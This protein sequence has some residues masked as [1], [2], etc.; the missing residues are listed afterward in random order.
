[1]KKSKKIKRWISKNLLGVK[2]NSGRPKKQPIVKKPPVLPVVKYQQQFEQPQAQIKGNG[3]NMRTLGWIVTVSVVAVGLLVWWL[4]TYVSDT[5]A[6]VALSMIGFF[7]FYMA[8][9]LMDTAKL[10]AHNES[11]RITADML[12]DFNRQDAMTDNYRQ[13]TTLENARYQRQQL[14]HEVEQ[15]KQQRLLLQKNADNFEEAE[16]EDVYD[17]SNIKYQVH[18]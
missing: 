1:M 10:R 12:T 17:W 11:Q 18:E 6:L 16:E 5:A 14:A 8:K 4:Q 9:D 2:Q 15:I 3:N 7:I 13:K